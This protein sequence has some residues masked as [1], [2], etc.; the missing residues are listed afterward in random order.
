MLVVLA[1]LAI[2]AG[3]TVPFAEVTVKRNKE[4]DLKRALRETRTA[5]DAFHDDWQNGVISKYGSYTSEDGYPK[6][7]SN[8]VDGVDTAGTRNVKKKYLRRI[9]ENPFADSNLPT[10][11]QWALRSY[12]DEKGTTQWGGQDVYDLY[13]AGDEKALDGSYYHDW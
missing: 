6:T 12:A 8:L 9:P 2:L 11:Q 13:C 4:M 1:I 7:L 10:D 3:V 5:I